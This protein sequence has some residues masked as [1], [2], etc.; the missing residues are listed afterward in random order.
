MKYAVHPGYVSAFDGDRH[1]ITAQQL[2]NL[3]GVNPKD[4]CVVD[5]SRQ[6][7]FIG[8][9]ITGYIHL[10]PTAN[11]D[12]PARGCNHKDERAERAGY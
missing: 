10:Y 1:Y 3:Y 12:Y 8:K 11:G 2:I 6:E 5:I 4:C 9:D 7:T